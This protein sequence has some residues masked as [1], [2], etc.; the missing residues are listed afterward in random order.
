[1]F[2]TFLKVRSKGLNN[3]L[4]SAAPLENVV[5]S[6]GFPAAFIGGAT[7]NDQERDTLALRLISMNV[8]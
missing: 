7:G 1:M 6:K 3:L 5:R 2:A 4:P 8:F